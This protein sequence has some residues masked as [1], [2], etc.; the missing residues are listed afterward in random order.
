MRASS[1]SA[2]VRALG[3][4]KRREY[5]RRAGERGEREGTGKQGGTD[6]TGHGREG[7]RKGRGRRD[8]ER[9][10]NGEGT[11]EGNKEIVGGNMTM[12]EGREKGRW[13]KRGRDKPQERRQV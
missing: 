10:E 3:I 12:Q 1:R 8:E 13:L 6:A 4:E 2:S 9:K 5:R 11:R 7:L